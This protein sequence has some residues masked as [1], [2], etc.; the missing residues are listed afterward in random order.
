MIK[1]YAPFDRQI[2]CHKTKRIQLTNSVFLRTESVFIK[3]LFLHLVIEKIAFPKKLLVKTK[4]A[5]ND[6]L[7]V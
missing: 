2:S 4:I 3:M 5:N 6:F 7:I 1:I